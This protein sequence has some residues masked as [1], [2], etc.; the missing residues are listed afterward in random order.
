[1]RDFVLFFFAVLI[2]AARLA[3]F[4][5]LAGFAVSAVVLFSSP[6]IRFVALATVPAARPT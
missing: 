6:V 3:F 2:A 5:D 4:R 1:V